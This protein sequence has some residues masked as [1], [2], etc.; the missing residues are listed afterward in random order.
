VEPS[1][2]GALSRLAA[3]VVGSRFAKPIARVALAAAGLALLAFVGRSS[4]AGAGAGSAATAA[5]FSAVPAAV[6]SPGAAP[7]GGAGYTPTAVGAQFGAAESMSADTAAPAPAAPTPSA[8][9]RAS[10]D[11]PVILNTAT[12]AELRRLPGVGAKRSDAILALRARLGRF[13]AIE[14][15]LKVKGIGRATL[16]RLRPLV[17]LDPPVSDAGAPRAATSTSR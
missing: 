15:L 16:K 2:P 5:T 17:R 4:I 11:D 10:P 3:R 1:F 9:D 7:P 6:L 12:D 14:D 13:R 8:R